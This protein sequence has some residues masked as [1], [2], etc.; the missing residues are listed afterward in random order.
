MWNIEI[1]SRDHIIA[2]LIIPAPYFIYPT[3]KFLAIWKN[4]I[5]FFILSLKT[6]IC[7]IIFHY[8]NWHTWFCNS[9]IIYFIHI[10]TYHLTIV[11]AIVTYSGWMRQ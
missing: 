3:L 10:F 8:Q 4:S 6:R 1:I 2:Q 5:I 7:Y 11:H 9:V